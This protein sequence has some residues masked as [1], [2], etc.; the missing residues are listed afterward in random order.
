MAA[1]GALYQL[2]GAEDLTAAVFELHERPTQ[3]QAMIEAARP[4][5]D[6][7]ACSLERIME[8][9]AALLRRCAGDGT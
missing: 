6:G 2:D 1:A 7:Q 3:R 9:L 4:Y 8:A 5:A